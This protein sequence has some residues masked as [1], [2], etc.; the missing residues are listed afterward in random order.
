MTTA[1]PV[2]VSLKPGAF[3]VI[4]R[5]TQLARMVPRLIRLKSGVLMA[6]MQNRRTGESKLRNPGMHRPSRGSASHN[7][8]SEGQNEKKKIRKDKM[9]GLFSELI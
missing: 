5:N 4:D 3:V 8:C 6:T 1:R 9:R 2:E 7:T